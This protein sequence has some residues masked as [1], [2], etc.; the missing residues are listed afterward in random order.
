MPQPPY[1]AMRKRKRIDMERRGRIRPVR[2]TKILGSNVMIKKEK[3]AI[4]FLFLQNLRSRSDS[5]LYVC[6]LFIWS[7]LRF[8]IHFFIHFYGIKE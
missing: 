1:S 7:K 3:S 4:L 8:F 2:T 6:S 5:S